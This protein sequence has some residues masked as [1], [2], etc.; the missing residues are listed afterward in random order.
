MSTY[1]YLHCVPCDADTENSMNHQERVLEDLLKSRR[2]V[3]ELVEKG[4]DVQPD[5]WRGDYAAFL[6]EHRGHAVQVKNEYGQVHCEDEGRQ[7]PSHSR[8]AYLSIEDLPDG[9]SV[10]D[11]AAPGEGP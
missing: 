11:T 10:R 3:E 8:P 1:W 4:F 6:H 7:P 2:A 9:I 5:P